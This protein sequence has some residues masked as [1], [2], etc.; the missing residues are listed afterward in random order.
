MA[1]PV[2]PNP[3]IHFAHR[4]L[5]ARDWQDRPEFDQLC[6]WWRNGAAGVCALVGIGGAGKTA[7]A[8]RFLRVLPKSVSAGG[9]Q[10]KPEKIIE[11]FFAPGSRYSYLAASQIPS[12]ESPTGCPVEWRPVHG[13]DVRALR[14]RDPFVGEPLSG[15]YAWNYRHRK[16]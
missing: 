12:L 8:E 2:S 13:L 16:F 7:I 15:Q 10:V 1:P 6:Q 11:F 5:R 14:G 9:G 3:Q 4:L